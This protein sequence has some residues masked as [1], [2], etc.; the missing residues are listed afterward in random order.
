MLPCL[1]ASLAV[2]AAPGRASLVGK[3]F[4]NSLIAT[5]PGGPT[6]ELWLTPDTRYEAEGR[7]HHA[8][9]GHWRVRGN[10]LWLSQMQRMPAPFSYCK[11]IPSAGMGRAQPAKAVTG[12]RIMAR[13][14]HGHREGAQR[15]A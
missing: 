2:S 8:S 12:E 13:L 10:R 1:S 15:K 6:A 11:S 3:T 9:R 7:K 14:I 5:Y 4:G